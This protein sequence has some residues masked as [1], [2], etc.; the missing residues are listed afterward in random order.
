[1]VCACSIQKE[2]GKRSGK[3]YVIDS[4]QI[5]ISLRKIVIKRTDMIVFIEVLLLK[6]HVK[7]RQGFN[8]PAEAA[9][10][11]YPLTYLYFPLVK[12]ILNL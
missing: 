6:M 5:S 1:M 10:L 4:K 3:W 2:K 8:Q 7:R 9:F 12:I 11:T